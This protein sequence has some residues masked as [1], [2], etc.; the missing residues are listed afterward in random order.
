LLFL[1]TIPATSILG[2]LLEKYRKYCSR[3]VGGLNKKLPLC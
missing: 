2:P 1:S 3:S